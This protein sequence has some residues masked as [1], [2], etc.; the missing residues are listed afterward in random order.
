M[1]VYQLRS[2][3]PCFEKTNQNIGI[4]LGLKDFAIFS[5]GE[6]VK[7]PRILKSFEVEYRRLTKSLS[8]KVKGSAN[9]QKAKIKLAKFHEHIANIRK[10]FLH[11]LSTR[12]VKTYDIVCC[13]TLSVKNMIKN[14]R[15]AKSFQDV[16]FSDFI[17]QLEYKAK[18]YGKTISKVDRFYP[19]SQL[20]SNCGFKN[21]DVK[22]LKI[23]EWICPECG[24]HH[25]RDINSAINILNEGLRILDF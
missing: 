9:Y 11:K 10:D 24:I 2:I 19:S 6:K 20:C 1:L 7:N 25:D 22:S 13:E 21:R 17:R 4:D 3:F 23:R 14:H 5:N 18:W 16:S 8:R 12:L 15:L